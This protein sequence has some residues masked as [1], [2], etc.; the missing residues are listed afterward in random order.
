MS[1]LFST[2]LLEAAFTWLCHS[3]RRFPANA[4]IW[5]L[6]HHWEAEKHRLHHQL[7]AGVYR[8]TPLQ[9]VTTQHGESRALWSSPDA[10][11]LKCLTLLLTDVL[12]THTA[13]EHIAGNGGGKQSIRRVHQVLRIDTYRY[14]CRT[15]ICGYYARINKSILYQQVQH[16]VSHP[17]LLDLLHQFLHYSVEDGG[18]F[19]TP[20]LGIARSSSLSP[21]LAAFHLFAVDEH[22]ANQP[23]LYYARYMDDFIIFT[24]SRWHLRRAVRELNQFF[25]RFGFVQHPD[26]T[27]IGLIRKGF[28]WMGAW[29]TDQGHTDIAPRALVNHQNTLRQLYEQTRHLPLERQASQVAEYVHRW[30][31]WA[32]RDSRTVTP[33]APAGHPWCGP[34][35]HQRCRVN[36]KY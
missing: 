30:N 16:H 17:T 32:L 24:R 29:F 35:N 6:R 3:R 27:F 10:L 18:N 5:H 8:L 26:K 12:P 2:D 25:S 31:T 34:A 19:H 36:A 4:D 9:V 22:F 15:D 28:D 1:D 21:L 14:A 33:C 20:K 23:H 13:C 11:V 7:N